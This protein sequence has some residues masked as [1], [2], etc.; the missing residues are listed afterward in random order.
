MKVVLFCG[1]L[2]T[3]LSDY[4]QTL[5]KAMVEIG[6]RPILWHLMKYYAHYGITEFILCLGYRGDCIKNY[7]RHYDECL[8]NDFVLTRG[9]RKVALRNR[10]ID[11]WTI[12]FADTGLQSNLAQRL[13]CVEKYLG[14]DDVFLA[15]YSDGLTDLPL[16]GYLEEFYR[17]GKVASFVAVRPSQ[18][19]H[20]VTIDEEGTVRNIRPATESDVWINGGFFAFRR[21]IFNY[22]RDGEDLVDGALQRLLFERQLYAHRYR[23]F[24]SCMDTFKEKRVFDALYESGQMPWAVWESAEQNGRDLPAKPL[25]WRKSAAS[26]HPAIRP[27]RGTKAAVS[28]SQTRTLS[29]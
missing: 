19:F 8:S 16:P 9:G 10:D 5:P 17:S 28:E 24:W 7:F 18:T 27:D 26:S 3:R 13:R 12:T 22:L 1:G 11:K 15:N 2:G 4:S 29:A 21:E 20:L 6:Y 23:G 25:G 14:D